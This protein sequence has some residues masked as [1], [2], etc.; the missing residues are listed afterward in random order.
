MTLSPPSIYMGSEEGQQYN[1]G[2]SPLQATYPQEDRPT[3][4]APR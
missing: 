1:S 3:C 2:P 4:Q